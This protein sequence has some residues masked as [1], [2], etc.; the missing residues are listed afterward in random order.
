MRLQRSFASIAML[1]L[2]CT[3]AAALEPLRHNNP[4]LTV[5]LGVGLWAWPLPM[6]WDGD[7]DLDLIVSCPDTPYN[8]TYFFENLGD[9]ARLPLFRAGQRVG[10]GLQN[11]QVSYVDGAPRVLTGRKAQRGAC[12]EL[13]N[14][15]GKGFDETRGLGLSLVDGAEDRVRANQWK[16]VDF[17]G[18][19]VLDLVHGAGL[20]GDYGWDNAYDD[21]GEW[22]RGPLHGYVYVF[23]NHGSNARPVYDPPLRLQARDQDIDVYGMPSPNF[24]DFDGD[25]DLDLLCGEFLDG[26]TYFHNAGT[27]AQPAYEPGVYLTDAGRKV[28]M[29]VQ[30]ITPTA[31]D[32]DHDG[33][34]DLVCGDEDGRVALVENAGGFRSGA[35]AFRQP[36]YF[37]QQADEVKFGALV[38][39]FAVDWDADGDE[40]LICGNTSGNIGFIENLGGGRVPRWAAPALLEAGGKPIH[41]QAGPRGSIQGPCEAKWGYTVVNV[42]DWDHDGLHDLVVNSIWGKVVWF[43]NIGSRSSPRLAQAQPVAIGWPDAPAKPAWNWWDPAPDELVTQWRTTPCVVD[44]NRDGLNDLVMLDHEGYLAFFERAKQ[45]DQLVLTPGKRVFKSGPGPDAQAASSLGGEN[46]AGLLR[47][48]SGQAGASGRRK[49]CLVDWDGDGD[50]DLLV[51]SANI[52]FLE[53]TGAQGG[54]TT[55]EDRGPLGDR[56]LAG[57][58]TCPTTVD[59][60]RDGVP[61]LLAGAEDGRLYYL[62]NPRKAERA[63]Q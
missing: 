33:D 40:D 50:L 43:R 25:G 22:R 63:E 61:D 3:Q 55:F 44:W 20:W 59:W 8:G 29:H 21:K 32:W 41:I 23:R 34:V 10:A 45:G 52:N 58:T 14:F 18:D 12:V 47:L 38:T 37:Q 51:N 35:P 28:A 56:K 26:F 53:N 36:V 1:A 4:G 49:F 13:L 7:G 42:A 54:M 60:D 39:P 2:A 57:H 31:L 46:G 30:M 15:L 24:A 19:G 62:A 11:A 17:D 16:Y 5:D 6:D 9:E 48:S 27:R